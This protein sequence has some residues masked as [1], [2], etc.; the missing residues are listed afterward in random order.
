MRILV[1][2]DTHRQYENLE[3]AIARVMPDKIFHAG[4]AEGGEDYIEAVCD[5]PLEIVRGNCDFGSTLPAEVVLGVGNHVVLL[6]HGHLFG[7]GFGVEG[8]AAEARNKDADVVI[9]G[10]T[11]CPQITYVDDIAI[12]NPGTISYPRQEG[13]KPSYLVIDVD[14]FGDLHY[15]ICYV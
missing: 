7:A 15:N 2:S 8:L 13:R 5:C 10:H 14:R 4:D 11:H 3:T 9:Y 6:T 1:V 12:V